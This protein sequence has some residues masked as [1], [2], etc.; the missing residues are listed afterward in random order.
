MIKFKLSEFAKKPE[1]SGDSIGN[2]GIDICANLMES[3]W[4][5]FWRDGIKRGSGRIWLK[6][7]ERVIIPTGVSAA[8]DAG[9]YLQV[10]DRSGNATKLG[11]HV[12]AGV[13]DSSYRGEIK[14]A[15]VNLGFEPVEITHG[16][17]VAQLIPIKISNEPI[18]IVDELDDTERGEKGGINE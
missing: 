10:A 18:E 17:K 11:V 13:I 3:E 9:Y 14:I 6:P 2:A 1:R 4:K 16:A 12:I 8:I 5:I 15:V 7:K